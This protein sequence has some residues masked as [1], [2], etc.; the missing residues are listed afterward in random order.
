[1]ACSDD[2][3]YDKVISM[4]IPDYKDG[5]YVHNRQLVMSAFDPADVASYDNWSLIPFSTH[6]IKSKCVCSKGV[7]IL[8]RI[9]HNE[10]GHVLTLGTN[11]A[12]HFTDGDKRIRVER[13]HFESEGTDL[14]VCPCGRKINKNN[15]T[16]RTKC[17]RCQPTKKA[18]VRLCRH[19]NKGRLRSGWNYHK[20][21][22]KYKSENTNKP[23]IGPL[24]TCAD[25]P[26][27]IPDNPYRP[28]CLS[29]WR[30]SR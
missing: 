10:T 2:I 29:C 21:C 8:H 28:R 18:N 30:H 1:M 27:T 17:N 13:R 22:Y 7:Q 11:C 5:H 26:A 14:R 25:C 23:V 15:K 24:T 20:K 4:N 3:T 16:G 19:C 6:R 12:E 9:K